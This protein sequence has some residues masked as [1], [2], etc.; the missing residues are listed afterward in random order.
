M[1]HA[2]AT[3]GR[4]TCATADLTCIDSD[5]SRII[6][7]NLRGDTERHAGSLL[8]TSS[9]HRRAAPANFKAA[10]LSRE[11]VRG[12]LAAQAPSDPGEETRRSTTPE[13]DSHAA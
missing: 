6:P 9:C 2:G 12:A 8:T 13:R 5:G 3:A 4:S 11:K 7:W 10:P 1:E